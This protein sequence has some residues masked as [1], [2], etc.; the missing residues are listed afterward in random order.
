MISEF[1]DVSTS[2]N[3]INYKGR[4]DVKLS[5]IHVHTNPFNEPKNYAQ[6]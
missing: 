6:T 5:F 3:S 2:E 4:I 1:S